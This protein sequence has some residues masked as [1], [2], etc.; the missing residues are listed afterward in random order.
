ME[1]QKR[2]PASI[3]LCSNVFVVLVSDLPT[4]AKGFKPHSSQKELDKHEF[5]MGK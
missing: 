3:P 2:V 4:A 1:T 5:E